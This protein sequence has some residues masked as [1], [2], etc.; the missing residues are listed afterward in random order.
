MKTLTTARPITASARLRSGAIRRISRLAEGPK[1]IAFWPTM[2]PPIGP[3]RPGPPIGASIRS[4][5]FMAVPPLGGGCGRRH[6]A[7]SAVS[8]EATISW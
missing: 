5:C 8:C 2:P 4:V 3:P 1:V 7:S 6:A